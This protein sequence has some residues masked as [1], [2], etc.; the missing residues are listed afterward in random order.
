MTIELSQSERVLLRKIFESYLSE[1]RHTIAAT[2]RGTSSMH[3]SLIH[4]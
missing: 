4:I 3:L 2:K 1:L